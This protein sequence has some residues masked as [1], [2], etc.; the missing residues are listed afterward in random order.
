MRIKKLLNGRTIQSKLTLIFA[1]IIILFNI[2]TISIYVSSTQLM[3]Q[4]HQEFETLL[5]LNSISQSAQDLSDK[6]KAYVLSGEEQDLEA[7]YEARENFHERTAPIMQETNSIHYKNYIN[8]IDALRY[9]T[10]LTT[11]FVLRDDMERYS[12]HVKEVDQTSSYIQESTLELLD[13]SLTEYQSLY[14]D[15]RERNEAFKYFTL[16]LLITSILLG[17][18]ITVRFSR[19]IHRPV[20]ALSQAAKEVSVGK[21]DGKSVQIQSPVELKLLGDSFNKM[22]E[23][24]R[25]LIKEIKDQ[26]EQERLMKELELKHLQNQ[27]QPHFLF[28]TLNTVSKMAYLEDAKS[29]SNLID[30]LASMMRHSLG[31]LKKT[32][33]LK[34]ELK[35]VE[36]YVAIQKMRFMERI[37]FDIDQLPEDGDLPLPRLTLQ[38]LVENAF[39]HGLE[40]LEEGGKISIHVKTHHSGVMVEV[41]DNGVGM[42]EEKRR[43]LIQSTTENE[44][45]VGHMTGIGLVNVIKRLQMFYQTDDVL[46]IDTRLGKGTIIRIYLPDKQQQEL[47]VLA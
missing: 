47:G 30:S 44:Q 14:A 11:G 3:Q 29:T 6:T 8:L 18:F 12:M 32:T 33:T 19:G 36:D 7:Y 31:D 20:Q 4:Y 13:G 41:A 15:I 27:I 22:R 43:Q 17:A 21:F 16:Y 39:I 25:N 46:E 24:I 9:Q 28:N 23:S 45:H 26:S 1:G 42:A 40:S 5:N 37:E 2:V 34:E 35:M 10:D 38:P